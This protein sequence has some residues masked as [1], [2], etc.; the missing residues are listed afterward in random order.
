MRAQAVGWAATQRS[1]ISQG[2]LD[3]TLGSHDGA[4]LDGAVPDTGAGERRGH[5]RVQA[6]TAQATDRF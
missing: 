3:P 5:C 1:R 2:L 4:D 6:L